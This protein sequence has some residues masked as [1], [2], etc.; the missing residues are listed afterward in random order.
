MSLGGVEREG[1]VGRRGTAGAAGE[2]EV[3]RIGRTDPLE[4]DRG[5]V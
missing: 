5:L 2:R 4:I 1:G 3:G